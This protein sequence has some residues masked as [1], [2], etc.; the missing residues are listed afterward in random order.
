[1]SEAHR[2]DQNSRCSKWPENRGEK[3]TQED[4]HWRDY[5]QCYEYFHGDNGAGP[6]ADHPNRL[7]VRDHDRSAGSR[8]R[9]SRLRR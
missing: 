9:Q 7:D 5:I 8:T 1:V 3:K 2:K 4:P 6:G